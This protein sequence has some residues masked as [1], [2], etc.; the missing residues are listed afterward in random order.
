MELS[1]FENS[2]IIECLLHVTW[3]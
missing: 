2:V 3:I 1:V